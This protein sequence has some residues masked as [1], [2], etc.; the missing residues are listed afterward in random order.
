[1]SKGM[2][3]SEGVKILLFASQ[4]RTSAVQ[5][6]NNVLFIAAF[7]FLVLFIFAIDLGVSRV[8]IKFWKS[9]KFNILRK[10]IKY[11]EIQKSHTYKYK[12]SS[13]VKRTVKIKRA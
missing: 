3:V 1:M 6:A 5:R 11:D 7:C 4:M 10:N 9:H 13:T 2:N 8:Q 12:Y